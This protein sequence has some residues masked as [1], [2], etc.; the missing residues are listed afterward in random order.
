MT[1]AG[2]RYAYTVL[3]GALQW[4]GPLPEPVDVTFRVVHPSLMPD[5]LGR[6]WQAQRTIEIRDGQ[7]HEETVR[8]LVHEMIHLGQGPHEE[9]R[10]TAH[11]GTMQACAREARWSAQSGC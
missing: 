6:C 9:A 2:L 4:S 11:T 10:W 8:T 1:S 5:A 7:T 3:R